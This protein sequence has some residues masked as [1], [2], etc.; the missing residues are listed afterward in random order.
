MRNG[1]AKRKAI[2]EHLQRLARRG[3][4]TADMVLGDAKKKASV[5]HS[6]FEWNDRIAAH[7]DRLRQAR[8]LIAEVKVYI[9]TSETVIA[10]PA[11]VRDPGVPARQQG[12]RF[13]AHLKP[14]R[15]R[16][17]EVLVSEAGRAAA[18]LQRVRDLA[19]GLDLVN[20]VDDTIAHFTVFRRGLD[21]A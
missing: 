17:L 6:E 21:A 10:V 3:R 8:V 12:Y 13:T 7:R 16:A 1:S 19:V 2:Y 15:E 14:D 11:F 20:E 4:L 9:E 18:Y 5:L